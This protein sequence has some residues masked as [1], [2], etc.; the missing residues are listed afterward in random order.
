MFVNEATFRF[1][2]SI[3]FS[4]SARSFKKYGT[5]NHVR[6]PTKEALIRHDVVSADTLQGI[7][8]KYGCSVSVPE[9]SKVE[10]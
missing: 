3:A 10:S 2:K 1:T 9:Q 4:D 6:N 8:L 7:S 5:C